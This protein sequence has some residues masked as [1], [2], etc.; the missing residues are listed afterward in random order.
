MIN[1]YELL[2]IKEKS[3]KKEIT[4]A[5]KTMVEKYRFSEIK[6][7]EILK[8]KRNL[9]EAK[10]TLLDDNKRKEYDT[11][12]Q[13]IRHSKQFSYEKEETYSVKMETY[14]D[15][16]E[17]TYIT[18]WE[19]FLNYLKYGTDK[20]FI[21]LF[22]SILSLINACFF[23]VLKGITFG[24]VYLLNV[25]GNFIDYIAGFIMIMA[26][27]MLFMKSA[28]ELNIIPFLPNNIECF[29]IYSI[30]AFI[31]EML[32]IFIIEKSLNLYAF[33]Q[34]IQDRILVFILMK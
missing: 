23:I 8:I 9:D 10:E 14:K 20:V 29:C 31:M 2:G 5:Y 1:F 16:Y 3:N 13:D 27:L 21:K 6:D 33:F 30:I 11:L 7:E 19:F 17:D 4:I 12:L 26:I 18:R 25:I 22:K 24:L 28:P 34:D 32:K 15:I